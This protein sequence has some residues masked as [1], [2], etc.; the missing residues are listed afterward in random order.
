[1]LLA[2]LGKNKPK[3]DE[4]IFPITR[5]KKTLFSDI[6]LL[7]KLILYERKDEKQFQDELCVEMYHFKSV[8]SE[9]F[10]LISKAH[11]NKAQYLLDIFC[12]L[13]E[14]IN[15][16]SLNGLMINKLI[17]KKLAEAHSMYYPKIIEHQYYHPIFEGDMIPHY[18]AYV[19]NSYSYI[20]EYIFSS[21]CFNRGSDCYSEH[22]NKSIMFQRVFLEVFM[23]S[24]LIVQEYKEAG[25]VNNPLFQRLSHHA[26]ELDFFLDRAVSMQYFVNYEMEREQFLIDSANECS[27]KLMIP[28]GRSSKAELEAP[29]SLENHQ[30][31]KVATGEINSELSEKRLNIEGI[32]IPN[33]TVLDE[34]SNLVEDTNTIR[35][36][37]FSNFEKE[38]LRRYIYFASLAYDFEYADNTLTCNSFW[39]WLE[40]YLT[41]QPLDTQNIDGYEVKIFFSEGEIKHLGLLQD[42]KFSSQIKES[43]F[44]T[45]Y[46]RQVKSIVPKIQD[47]CRKNNIEN[48]TSIL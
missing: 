7:Y 28:Y 26:N 47:F 1:M 35:K 15:V 32:E 43:T 36:Q 31:D 12:N 42:P 38:H 33:I 37:F 21:T 27:D 46:F 17:F 13:I 11:K 30:Q 4:A 5:K 16:N 23:E 19:F 2:L 6:F 22:H 14:K 20:P 25:T 40:N 34:D 48:I 3:P 10:Q 9:L 44:R 18:N 8:A 29:D 39:K 24:S 45:M 41:N